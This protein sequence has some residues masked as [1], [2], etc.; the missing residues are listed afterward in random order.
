MEEYTF[1]QCTQSKLEEWFGLR[2]T[3][4]N[5]TLDRWLQT[6]LALSDREK[7][8]LESYQELLLVNSNAWNEQE[9]SLHF[10]GPV[11]GLVHFTE[12]YRFNLFAERKIGAIV[13]GIS[14]DIQLSGEPDGLIAT[15]YWE[16]K[17]PF[18][19]FS[20]YKRTLDPYGDP[21]GQALAAMLV[22]QVLNE[23]PIPLYGCYV[24]GRQW[25]FLVLENNHY[26]ISRD[27]SAST[28]EIFEIFR[29]LKALKGIIMDL[30]A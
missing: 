26:T 27:F 1:G 22:A 4:S 5:P 21:A 17:I 18:F 20:E 10:I 19:A 30:T 2:Q 12:P 25:N 13:P 3:F 11:F 8:V 23:R 29:V 14:G 7:I 6:D 16:P 15:G 28:D 24:V 9:L